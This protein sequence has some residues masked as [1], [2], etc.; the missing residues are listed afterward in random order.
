M[1]CELTIVIPAYNE[2]ENIFPLLGRLRSALNDI[3]WEVIFVDDDSPDGTATRVREAALDDP[4]VRLVR[5]LGRRGLSS[6]CIEGML[7]SCAPFL[8]VMDA[9]MQH[10]ETIIPSMLKAV[11]SDGFD[12][13]VGSRYVTGGGMEN[14]SEDR[15]LKSLRATRFAQRLTG[16]ELTDPMSGFFLLRRELLERAL[17]HL[18]GRGFKILL[19]IMMSAPQPVRFKDIPYTFRLRQQGESKLTFKVV[20]DYFLLVFDKALRRSFRNDPSS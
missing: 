4:R 20:V 17:R 18:N 14:W 12:I 2:R 5:R 19:D 11:K 9:D 3:S 1:S 16:V 7:A 10:D 15:K 8:A 13:A 6:A